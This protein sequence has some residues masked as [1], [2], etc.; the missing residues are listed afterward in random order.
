[1]R[2]TQRS[3]DSSSFW[4]SEVTLNSRWIS[5]DAKQQ[6]GS[7]PKNKTNSSNRLLNQSDEKLEGINL[8]GEECKP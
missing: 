5:D 8:F 6:A 7:S 2:D 3:V 4:S 1:M